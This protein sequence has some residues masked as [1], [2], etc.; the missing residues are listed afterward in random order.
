[1]A[2][3]ANRIIAGS[4]NA[5]LKPRGSRLGSGMA[6]LALL[7]L[8]TLLG[9]GCASPPKEKGK[10]KPASNALASV[11]IKGNTPG[12]IAVAA[13][14]V[15]QSEGYKSVGKDLNNLRFEREGSDMNNIAHGQWMGE[16]VWIRV[17]VA[18]VSLGENACQLQLNAFYV[19][20][21]GRALETEIKINHL[22]R[23]PYQTLLD[24]VAERFAR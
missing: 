13:I 14:D 11:I 17:K 23:K 21:R 10:G 15:F 8:C 12:Q 6:L 2:R 16:K 9:A 24:A 4:F 7:C 22:H 19:Q 1:M 20:D 5:G 18:V 3:S